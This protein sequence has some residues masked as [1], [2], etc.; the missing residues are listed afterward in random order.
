MVLYMDCHAAIR[1]ANAQ[2]NTGIGWDASQKAWIL[3]DPTKGAPA[4]VEPEMLCIKSGM[5]PIPLSESG[6][7]IIAALFAKISKKTA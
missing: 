7:V 1:D 4:G 6:K 2:R 5:L 3:Y